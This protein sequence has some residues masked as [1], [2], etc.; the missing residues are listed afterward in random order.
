MPDL[1][2][3]RALQRALS[4]RVSGWADVLISQLPRLG[5]DENALL[6]AF[7]VI[8][9]SAVGLSVIVFYKLIDLVQAGALTAAGRLTGIGS[10]AIVLV[11][12]VGLSVARFLVRYAATDSDG[13]NIPDVMRAVAKRG[14]VVHTWPVL[15]KTAGAAIAIGTG[16]S[17][18][19]EAPVAVVG[20]GLGSKIG[21]FFPCWSRAVRR[22]G[23]RPRSTPRS[24]ACSSPS[25]R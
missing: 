14:G 12:V 19:A 20:S 15:V 5:I 16:G 23:S 22:L 2:R 13:E 1:G 9:G 4:A 24:P 11:V 18:G 7:A 3:L 6:L 17:V 25:R 21:R 10:L 8:I